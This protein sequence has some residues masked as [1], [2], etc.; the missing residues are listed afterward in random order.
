MNYFQK[1]KKI[2]KWKG[3]YSNIRNL[4]GGGPQGG[5]FGILEYLCQSNDNFNMIE[6]EDRFKFVDDLSA[7]E[8]IYLICIQ[9][10]SYNFHSHVPSDI[11]THNGCIQSDELAS[12]KNLELVNGQKKKK[13]IL[14]RPRTYIVFIL[15]AHMVY[16]TI[17]QVA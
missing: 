14:R 10:S 9:V 12:Q 16:K 5:I 4:P 15:I 17:K 13:T 11:L 7:L 8:I 1:R 2:V 6:P 3:V